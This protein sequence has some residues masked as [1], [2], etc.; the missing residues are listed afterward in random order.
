MSKEHILA[1]STRQ[2]AGETT[3][4]IPSSG[5]GASPSADQPIEPATVVPEPVAPAT[6]AEPT[7]QPGENDIDWKKRHDDSTRE[8]Q[9]LAQE[10][11]DQAEEIARLKAEA[12]NNADLKLEAQLRGETPEWDQLDESE[13]LSRLETARIKRRGEQLESE[14]AKLKAEKQFDKDFVVLVQDPTMALLKDQKEA[15]RTYTAKYPNTDLAVLARSFMYAQHGE[16]SALEATERTSRQGL[17][18]PTGAIKPDDASRSADGYTEEALKTLA[19]SNPREFNRV[20]QKRAVFNQARS[21]AG[22]QR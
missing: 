14:N 20:M 22:H 21:I 19:N 18:A 3:P 1:T 7:R 13:R 5:D 4:E 17:E 9:R 6:E 16:Q 15:F 11:K 2:P 10:N 8:A 12:E